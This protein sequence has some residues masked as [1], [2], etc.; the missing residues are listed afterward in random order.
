MAPN[1]GE[2]PAFMIAAMNRVFHKRRESFWSQ[3]LKDLLCL[4]RAMFKCGS[5]AEGER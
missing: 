3:R 1:T 2:W 4:V 5:Y